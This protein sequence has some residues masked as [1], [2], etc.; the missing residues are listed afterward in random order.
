MARYF[1]TQSGMR[2]SRRRRRIYTILV[3]IIIAIVIVFWLR[4]SSD[5]NISVAAESKAKEKITPVKPAFTEPSPSR[6]KREPKPAVKIE[7][8][9]EFPEITLDSLGEPN[10]VT[11]EE[12]AKAMKCL[13]QGQDGIIEARD[14]L[15]ETLSMPMNNR[16]LA[17]VKK[18]LSNLSI[19]WLFSRTVFPKDRLCSL[20]KVQPGDQLRVIGKKHKIPFEILLEINN[21]DNPRNLRAGDTIKVING[22]FHAR[23]YRSTF[24]MDLYLQNTFVR[25]FFVGLGKPGR[26]TPTGLWIVEPG[27][28]LIKPTWTDPDTGK[29]YDAES[30]DY[31]LGSRWI[32]L[33]GL[34]GEAV[35]R[36][37]IAFHGIR[38]EDFAVI[39]K[40]GSRGCIRLHNGDAKLIYNLL[41]PGHSQVAIQD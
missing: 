32:R 35:G 40:S 26:E 18:Q 36:T 15:N 19:K 11:A 31:P 9:P 1:S 27:G 29:T 30:P 21:I 34:K 4:T 5:E 7:P 17:F 24:S 10:S 12:I 33:K 41:A 8:E 14:R 2:R 3:L 16:Q 13:E 37:G 28:K 22:P 25:N 38:D 6:S 23:I 20:Y 39:G